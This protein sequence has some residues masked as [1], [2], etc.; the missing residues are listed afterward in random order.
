[1][2]GFSVARF[3]VKRYATTKQSTTKPQ[4]MAALAV[5]R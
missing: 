1:M 3:V 2:D 5:K 4:F